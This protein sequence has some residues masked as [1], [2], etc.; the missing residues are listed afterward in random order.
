MV[1]VTPLDIWDEALLRSA[2]STGEPSKLRRD[3][4]SSD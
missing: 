4:S 2:G 3:S 1:M